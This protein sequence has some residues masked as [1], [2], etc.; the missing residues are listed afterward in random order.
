M[1]TEFEKTAQE[2][3]DLFTT[4]LADHKAFVEKGT[5]AAGARARLALGDVKKLI[6]PY[7]KMSNEIAKSLT[8]NK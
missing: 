1:N 7:R 4:F 3:T 8:K 2:I 5:K 6:T